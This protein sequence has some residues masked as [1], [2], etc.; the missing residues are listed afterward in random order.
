M[1]NSFYVKIY[2]LH[3]EDIYLLA[4]TLGFLTTI[5][6]LISRLCVMLTF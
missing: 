6:Y 4:G 1:T 5:I 2:K 3:K